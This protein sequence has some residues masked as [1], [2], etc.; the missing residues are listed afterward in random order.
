MTEQ[1][2]HRGDDVF[3]DGAGEF[4]GAQ[5]E[6][7]LHAHTHRLA[8]GGGFLAQR[9]GQLKHAGQV[10]GFSVAQP[11]Q[12]KRPHGH[13]VGDELGPF[14]TLDGAG[15]FA[16]AHV[17]EQRLDFF[18]AWREK[19]VMFADRKPRGLVRGVA[20]DETGIENFR[21]QFHHAADQPLFAYDGCQRFLVKAVLDCDEH[22]IR[23]EIGL[24]EFRQPAVIVR[25]HAHEHIVEHQLR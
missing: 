3:L 21:R 13:A 2:F 18:H 11:Q 10:R 8:D 16:H 6:Y 1:R 24:D 5:A 4:V 12:T 14:G 25:F 19:P 23:L 20:L 22:A 7:R 17:I 15:D 9:H